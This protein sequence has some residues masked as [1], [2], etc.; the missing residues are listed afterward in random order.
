M[1]ANTV[2]TPDMEKPV[3]YLEDIPIV[4][5]ITRGKGG[6][7][8]TT[9][10]FSL[11]EPLAQRLGHKVLCVDLDPAGHLSDFF[12]RTPAWDAMSM[13]GAVERITHDL[14]GDPVEHLGDQVF[15]QDTHLDGVLLL[16][17]SDRELRS[18]AVELR[19]AVWREAFASF[20]QAVADDAG[21]QLILV[22][23][24]G[25]GGDLGEAACY[26]ATYLITPVQTDR[27]S[28]R[29]TVLHQQDVQKTNQ[30]RARSNLDPHRQRLL[31]ANVNDRTKLAAELR[32]TLRTQVMTD[33]HAK[34]F[35]AQIPSS[36]LVRTLGHQAP[37]LP[38]TAS[39]QNNPARDAYLWVADE[40]ARELVADRKAA[41]RLAAEAA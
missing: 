19:G 31:I 41:A 15:A 22:D 39:G 2:P 20:L 12:R 6:T 34:I 27:A 35:G 33:P 8:K 28:I 3:M 9:S 36:N 30:I 10:I 21:A 1:A 29:S 13:A 37:A 23:T 40:F 38:V 25:T 11:A 17:A 5:F 24:P 16:P 4:P 14:D 32:Q 26:K 7:A 18:M